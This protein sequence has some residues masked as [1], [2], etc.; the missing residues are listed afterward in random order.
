MKISEQPEKSEAVSLGAKRKLLRRFR[1]KYGIGLVRFGKLARI[2]QPMLSQFERGDRNLS[3]EAWVR[4]LDTIDKL[5]AEGA[6]ARAKEI[7]GARKVAVKLDQQST[8]LRFAAVA[9]GW[10]NPRWS[11]DPRAATIFESEFTRKELKYLVATERRQFRRM[12]AAA[13]RHE[14]ARESGIEVTKLI[15]FET[16]EI[17]LTNDETERWMKAIRDARRKNAAFARDPE[18]VEDADFDRVMIAIAAGDKAA[19][20]ELYLLD[21]FAK[22]RADLERIQ[23]LLEG[24]GRA[25]SL[26]DPIFD[27]VKLEL[28]SSVVSL[29]HELEEAAAH[30]VTTALPG[31]G[32]QEKR[33]TR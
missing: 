16:G 17:H 15:R 13:T 32:H 1:K 27:Y 25:R 29:S 31:F 18:A 11:L 20:A 6:T 12:W 5:V 30:N 14:I 7:Q 26:T 22:K 28:Q 10:K 23:D 4:V 3:A 8:R 24:M 9:A 19:L 2:S 33:K 21:G